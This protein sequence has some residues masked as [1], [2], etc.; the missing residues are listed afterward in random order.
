MFSLVP[1]NDLRVG[2]FTSYAAE[3]LYGITGR[4]LIKMINALHSF[5]EK[6]GIPFEVF[7]LLRAKCS[8]TMK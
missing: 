8:G 3:S 6:K 7:D 4:N 5:I 1:Q 2:L